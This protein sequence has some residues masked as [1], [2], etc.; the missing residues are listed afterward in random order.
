MVP[1]HTP[2]GQGDRGEE[3]EELEGAR[4]QLCLSRT[5]TMSEVSCSMNPH[6]ALKESSSLAQDCKEG[7]PW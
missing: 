6:T 4:H 2:V 1:Q 7:D 5:T 3:R